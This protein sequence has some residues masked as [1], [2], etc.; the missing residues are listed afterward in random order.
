MAPA[1]KFSAEKQQEM[2]LDA[3]IECIQETS[4]TDFP[5]AKIARMAGLS[6]GSIYK[7]FQCKEDIVLALANRSF[8]HISRV[9]SQVLD[10]PI[11]T[12]EKFVAVCLI[13]PKKLQLYP[14]A[15]ELESYATN[16]AVIRKA[17]PMWTNKVIEASESCEQSFKLALTEGITSGELGE[18]PNVHEF[19]EEIT[20]SGWAMTSGYE[21]VIRI[22]QTRQINEGT[23]SLLEPLSINDPMI[24][25]LVRLINSY[26]WKQ[27][28]TPDS[29]L[30]VESQ[31]AKLNLR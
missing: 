5:M 19:I 18:I 30:N 26:P 14:F 25:S 8:K 23:S 16:E 10:L 13:S 28:L 6:M 24:R 9:F 20:I 4:V 12:P 29:L 1:P 3:A 31:L 2:I 7:F 22:K 11:S 21:Q 17:S 15:Y 27:P